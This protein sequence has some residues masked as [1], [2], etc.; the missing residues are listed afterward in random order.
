MEDIGQW[1]TWEPESI[2]AQED[3]PLA[4]FMEM[5]RGVEENGTA[6]VQEDGTM[7]EDDAT[8]K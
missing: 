4:P 5:L 7:V 3:L 8:A 6:L 2:L 1:V